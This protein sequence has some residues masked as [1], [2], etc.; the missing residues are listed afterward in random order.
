MTHSMNVV[1]TLDQVSVPCSVMSYLQEVTPLLRLLGIPW[2]TLYKRDFQYLLFQTSPRTI[3][4]TI[5][6]AERWMNRLPT[7]WQLT[8]IQDANSLV[9]I[10]ILLCLF[11]KIIPCTTVEIRILY[12]FFVKEMN[13]PLN[14]KLRKHGSHIVSPL[15]FGLENVPVV[16]ES[17]AG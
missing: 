1:L 16:E 3:S 14:D 7:L 17:S 9:D 4:F 13:V 10:H 8:E 12:F 6:A 15:S 2:Q 11:W 5:V